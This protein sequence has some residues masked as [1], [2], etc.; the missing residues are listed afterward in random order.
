MSILDLKKI[1]KTISLSEMPDTR[2]G[3]GKIQN[4]PNLSMSGSLFLQYNPCHST[5]S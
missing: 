1:I 5:S 2:G 4:E 3:A